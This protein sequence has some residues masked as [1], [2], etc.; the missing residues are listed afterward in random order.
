M[1]EIIPYTPQLKGMWDNAVTDS[2]NGLFQHLRDYM[3]YHADRFADCSLLASDAKGRIIAVLPAHAAGDEVSSHRGLTFGGWLM[4]LRADM[5]AM[6]EVWAAMT[7]YYRS[8]G[9]HSLYYR[10]APYIYHRYPAEEDIYALFRAGGE[11]RGVQVSSVVDNSCPRGFDMA[12][13]QSV[14]KAAAAGIEA[15][16]SS[17]WP[18]F[19]QIL[20]DRLQERYDSSPVHGLDEIMLLQSRFPEQIR[21][22]TATLEGRIIA[23]VVI[24]D[25]GTAVHSQYCAST[26]EGRQSRALPFLYRHI[27]DVYARRRF[28]DFG[29]S[30]EDG[31]MILNEGLIRQKCGFGGR[32]VAYNAYTVR[33]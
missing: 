8:C 25:C 7:E 2:R 28:F 1:I 23:G 30:N 11:L 9:F 17:Q 24:Y 6:M 31:G 19:W 13:R 20:S 15:G 26:D 4:T 5:P 16:E 29:T 14:R 10:P 18:L 22:F 3:D 27:L 12:S 21:L 32:A 33:F